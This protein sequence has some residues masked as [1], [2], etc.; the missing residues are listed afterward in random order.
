MENINERIQ[1]LQNE[2]RRIEREQLICRIVIG[3]I[4]IFAIIFI[5][6]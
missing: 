2:A 4:I 5:F 6:I 3:V 1:I